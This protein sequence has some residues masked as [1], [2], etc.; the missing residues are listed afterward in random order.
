MNTLKTTPYYSSKDQLLKAL[1][2]IASNLEI[3]PDLSIAHP[4]YTTFELDVKIR[5]RFAQLPEELK[6]KYLGLRLRSF[7]HETYYK[8][9]IKP[10][11]ESAHN[12]TNEA[13]NL[14]NNIYKGADAKFYKQLQAS[15]SGIGYFDA[16]WL[17]KDKEQDGSLAVMKDGLTLYIDPVRHLSLA[18]QSSVKGNIVSVRMPKNLIQSGYYIAVS[19]IGPSRHEIVEICFNISPEGA[20]HLMQELTQRLN[21]GIIPFTLK[22]LHNPAEYKCHDPIILR[23]SRDRYEAIWKI[24]Q[25]IYRRYAAY[26]Q[27]ETPLFTKVLAPGLALAEEPEQKFF[28]QENFGQNRCQVIANALMD[29]RQEGDETA[30]KRMNAILNHLSLHEISLDHP[31]LNPSSEDVY[32]PLKISLGQPDCSW[33]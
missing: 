3:K 6:N 22:A 31:Y 23:F 14:E 9:S 10:A 29:A 4:A 17:L 12:L 28:D 20:V 21:R 5:F 33:Q 1:K 13:L 8:G 7:L 2:D 11:R 27:P 25:P 19:D 16:G 24:L 18:E 30:E 26:F 32:V 15:N